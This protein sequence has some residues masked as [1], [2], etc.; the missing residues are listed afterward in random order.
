MYLPPPNVAFTHLS[1]IG[2][3]TMK[4]R[5]F[6]ALGMAALLVA[7]VMAEE[8][9]EVKLDGIKCPV[10]GKA[11]TE[12]SVDYKGGKVYFCCENCPKA[13]SADSK[14]FAAKANAQLVATGQAKQAKC[15]LTGG[16]LNPDTAITVAGAKV[17][18]CCEKCQG[19]VTAAKGDEQINLVFSD[20]AFEK[21]GYKVGDKK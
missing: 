5:L 9:K 18:F 17:C 2:D 15:P 12:N 16:K 21:A 3:N 6:A 13:F 4:A 20:A 19:K 1:K 14:K 8:K 11:A 10:S 7:T